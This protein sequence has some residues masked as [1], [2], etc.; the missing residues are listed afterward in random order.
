MSWAN[1]DPAVRDAATEALTEK[2]LEA[3]VYE[4]SGVGVQRMARL[5]GVT[6]GA[7]VARLDGA[8]LKLERAG[9][10]QDAFGRYYVEEAA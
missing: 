1:L 6:K 8:H 10:R 4:C 7:V 3:F 2:Q 5:I 9:V